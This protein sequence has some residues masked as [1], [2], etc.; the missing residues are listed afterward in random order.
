MVFFLTNLQHRLH[1]SGRP[2]AIIPIVA[3]FHTASRNV[4]IETSLSKK[5]I[6]EEELYP[7][8]RDFC[9]NDRRCRCLYVD[10]NDTTR[11]I[12]M[13]KLSNILQY[14]SVVT[15]KVAQRSEGSNSKQLDN[16][17]SITISSTSSSVF[18][19][20][21]PFAFVMGYLFCW[22]PFSDNGTNER[23]VNEL[24]NAICNKFC[25]EV[26]FTA[27]TNS[28]T[29]SNKTSDN[30]VT[31]TQG[32]YSTSNDSLIFFLC[33]IVTPILLAFGYLSTIETEA[34]VK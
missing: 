8:L 24:V 10:S 9:Q 22:L 27:G 21:F 17:C 2:S 28:T 1:G 31:S 29:L 14:L 18:P 3:S 32:Y 23:Y 4:E 33:F 16:S 34:N 7:M 20:W 15:I 13:H 25:S 11:T 12:T 6:T 5:K 26:T 30:E 19:T